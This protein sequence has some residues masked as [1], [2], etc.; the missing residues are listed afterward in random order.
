MA[1]I[2][3]TTAQAKLDQYLAAETKVLA[4]QKI[5]IDGTVF[6][7]ADLAAIQNGITIWNKRVQQASRGCIPVRRLQVMD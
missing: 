1:G 5:E 7:R 2:D 6:T 4:G 3:L